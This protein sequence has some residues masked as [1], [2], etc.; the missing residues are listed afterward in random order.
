MKKYSVVFECE[1]KGIQEAAA[2][3]AEIAKVSAGIAPNIYTLL[4]CYADKMMFEYDEDSVGTSQ[5]SYGI[6]LL[7]DMG[8]IERGSADEEDDYSMI[9]VIK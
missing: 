5:I 2:T 9:W 8:Y 6:S 1:Y 7:E 3:A 4:C